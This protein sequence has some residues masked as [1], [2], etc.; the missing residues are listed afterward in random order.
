LALGSCG[1]RNFDNENDRLRRLTLEQGGKIKALEAD[2][3]ELE[4]KLAEANRAREAALD[5][6]V[7]AAL[8]RC[9]GIGL[10][11][12]SGVQRARDGEAGGPR[13]VAFID[14][15]DG[16][17]RFVQIVGTLT[18]DAVIAGPTGD[19]APLTVTATLGPADVREAYRTTMTGYYYLVE[20]P[21][22]AGAVPGEGTVTIRARFVDALSGLTHEAEV[23]SR[24]RPGS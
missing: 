5:P 24:I 6:D 17:Q 23:T 11:S 1:A 13:V 22:D 7:L 4:A 3:A 19:A 20:I 10:E 9:A 12:L 16:R 15:F 18:V 14:P 8:P 21:V 2:R